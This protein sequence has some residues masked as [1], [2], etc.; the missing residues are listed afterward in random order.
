MTV[1]ASCDSCAALSW[2]RRSDRGPAAPGSDST[3]AAPAGNAGTLPLRQASAFILRA[4]A[5]GTRAAR[6]G[7]PVDPVRN[8]QGVIR[9]G[10]GRETGVTW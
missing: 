4:Q 1:T 7:M 5:G 6:T 3:V 8:N 2:A 9:T 10:R